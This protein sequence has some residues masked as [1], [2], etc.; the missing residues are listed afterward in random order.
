MKITESA[1]RDRMYSDIVIPNGNEIEFITFARA[2]G[3][4]RLFFCY[5]EMNIA[6]MSDEIEM[7]K[8]QSSFADKRDK[9]IEVH[10]ICINRKIDRAKFKGLSMTKVD[11]TN[12]AKLDAFKSDIFYGFEHITNRDGMHQRLSGLNHVMAKEL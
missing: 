10:P 8:T 7:Y 11:N 1:T 3:Y 9:P 6:K 5:D 2:L 12:I 4:S